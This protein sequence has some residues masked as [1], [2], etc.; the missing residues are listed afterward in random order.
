MAPLGN[1]PPVL[2][3]NDDNN[4]SGNENGIDPHNDG[5]NGNGTSSCK[6]TGKQ[7]DNDNRK[8]DDNEYDADVDTE[9]V[10]ESKNDSSNTTGID[11]DNKYF[12]Q[13]HNTA[14]CFTGLVLTTVISVIHIEI[15]QIT[16]RIIQLMVIITIIK[17]KN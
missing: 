2:D 10:N 9:N 3:N 12:K 17:V 13:Q 16:R 7:H 4:H 5:D 1:S 11:N 15:A 6:A 14:A 8:Q